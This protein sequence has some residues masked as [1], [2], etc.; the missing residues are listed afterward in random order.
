[1]QREEEH[2]LK[3]SHLL[4]VIHLEGPKDRFKTLHKEEF[5]EDK[6][7]DLTRNTTGIGRDLSKEKSINWK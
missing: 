3:L 4:P 7:E 5:A 6:V 2:P 1:L